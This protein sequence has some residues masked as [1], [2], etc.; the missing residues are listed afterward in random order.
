M[1]FILGTAGFLLSCI[2]SLFHSGTIRIYKSLWERKK[3]NEDHQQW[4]LKCLE[5]G[6]TQQKYFTGNDPES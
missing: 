6:N 5:R 3:G 4:T 1:R 2:P